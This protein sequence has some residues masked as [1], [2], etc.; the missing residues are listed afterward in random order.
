MGV[1]AQYAHILNKFDE[2]ELQEVVRVA[3]THYTDPSWAGD[4]KKIKGQCY[5]EVQLHGPIDLKKHVQRLV[6]HPKHKV[7]GY[8]HKAIEQ[9]CNAHGWE[10]S[11]M[12]QECSMRVDK[13]RERDIALNAWKFAGTFR[14]NTDDNRRTN[15]P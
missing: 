14:E 8:A 12:D 4:A 13:M 1:P 11:W 3:N 10:L 2:E 15:S 5:K 9:L 6:V 7:D